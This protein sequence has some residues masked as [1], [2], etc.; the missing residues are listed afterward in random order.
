MD[1]V[2]RPQTWWD[3]SRVSAWLPISVVLSIM[4]TL[5][6]REIGND[7]VGYADADRTLMDGVF[8][9]DFLKDLPL[10][11]VY[12][13]TTQ[14]YG[15]YPALSIG[16]HPP[17]FPF[18]E[19]LFNGLFGLN[20]W[21]SR[22]AIVAFAVVGVAAW[23]RLIERIFD[24]MTAFWAMLLLVTTPFFVQWGWYAMGEIPAVSLIMAAAY[25]FYRSTES[26][27]ASYV[28]AAA[29]LFVLAVWTKHTAVYAILWF[30]L[31][32]TV[33]GKLLEYFKRRETWI[34]V[35]GLLL[36]LTPLAAITLWLGKMNL[37]QS[38]GDAEH[39]LFR[40]GSDDITALGRHLFSAHLSFPVFAL[41]GV[42][43]VWALVRRDSRIVFFASL[44]LTTYLF[45]TLLV[46]K[47]AR[48]SIYWIPAFALFASLPISY[49]RVP[50]IRVGF[51]FLLAG[52]AVYQM[53]V[54]YAK[55][56]AYA[57]GYDQAAAYVLEHSTSPTIFFDGHNNGYFIYF[58]RVF[59]PSRSMYVLR[60]DK[61]LSSSAIFSS[62]W[63]EVHAHSDNDIQAIFDRFGVE[64][65]VVESAD[66][67]GLFIHQELRRFLQAGPFE[68]QKTID[69]QSNRW[70]LRGQKLLIY[71]YAHPKTPEASV[72]EMRLPV[73]G[74][75]LRISVDDIRSG[76]NPAAAGPGSGK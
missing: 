16:Y 3:I 66:R 55:A 44:V 60:G 7:S 39:G 53:N 50:T 62:H 13:Y 10:T 47:D 34:A 28:Y 70:P 2:R 74:Q 6:M 67:T 26:D 32:L 22:L 59:D 19:A 75:T 24:S 31:Y 56:P 40:V 63:L 52:T 71:R 14:Y 45:F 17:L 54:V 18:V 61:L 25:M 5:M 21:S 72:M 46:A 36:A 15:Q 64:Y 65:I 57:T 33:R 30:L 9:L 37:F 49:L 48:Y 76:K 69:V 4:I 43:F 35:G 11:R 41:S 12:E 38:I 51:M 58:S 42:G 27:H 73:V 23:H 68:L 1:L 20:T 29:V 8:L